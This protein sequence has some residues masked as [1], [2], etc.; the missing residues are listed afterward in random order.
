[1]NTTLVN[2]PE[3]SFWQGKKLQ[4]RQMWAKDFFIQ[5]PQV[6]KILHDFNQKLD[7]CERSNKFQAMLVIGGTG[8]GK[9]T[10]TR[11]M[12][13]IAQ[14]RFMREDEEKTIRP[15]IQFAVPD[16]CTPFELSVSI[17][18]ALGEEQPRARKSRA[19]TIEAAEKMLRDCEVKLVLMDNVQDIP[20]RRGARGVEMVGA[21]LRNLID[22]S[23]ALWVLLGTMEA[24]KVINSDEQLIRRVSYRTKLTY[25]DV[26][27]QE[28]R[29]VFRKL[30]LEID[31]WLPL[32]SKS[33]L[34]DQV[35]IGA[36]FVATEGI[37]D[38]LIQLLDRAWYEAFLKEREVMEK[39]DLK[40][41][42]NYVYACSKDEQ[43]PFDEKFVMRNLNAADEPFEKL[44]G[45]V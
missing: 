13:E 37:F 41:A 43:N 11:K 28:Q 34:Q 10:L 4:E 15:S 39:L 45:G 32:S 27:E 20:E 3:K 40:N 18:R 30:L 2:P 44:R 31:Q 42:F 16:P 1:M 26:K 19:E 36:I 38:K 8:A 29:K 24:N 35:N 25:F 12:A 17:L 23:G 5:H 22:A 21:R 9:T 7:Y 14:A 6:K 33:C